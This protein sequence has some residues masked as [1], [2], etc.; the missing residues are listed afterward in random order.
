MNIGWIG[1]GLMGAPMVRRLL[2]AGHEV[3]LYTRSGSPPASLTGLDLP[4][5]NSVG[6]LARTSEVVF[7]ILGG[8]RDVEEVYLSADGLASNTR[9]GA[10]LVDMTTSSVEVAQRVASAASE[11]GA[12]A[13]DAPVSGGPFGAESGSLSIMVGGSASALDRVRDVLSVLGRV[14]VHHGGSGAG[15]CAKLVNQLVVAAVTESCAEAFLVARRAG[16]DIRNVAQSLSAGAAGSP[17]SRFVLERL[18]AGDRTPGFKVSHLRKDLDLVVGEGE[19]LGLRLPLAELARDAAV[20]VER[21]LGGNVGT[22]M[23]GSRLAPMAAL[24]PRGGELP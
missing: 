20:E 6:E 4:V 3:T 13:L 8:P 14:V 21:S 17:L 9:I 19:R 1:A 18:D 2:E 15:Q 12:H 16:L 10:V 22:Q 7:T 23:I 5:A 11:R 24:A